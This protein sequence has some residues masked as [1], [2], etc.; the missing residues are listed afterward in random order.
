[1]VFIL[2][3]FILVQFVGLRRMQFHPAPSRRFQLGAE[4]A[5][6]IEHR[7]SARA[8]AAPMPREPPVTRAVL[9]ES[10]LVIGFLHRLNFD[11]AWICPRMWYRNRN[12]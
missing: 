4:A 3:E 5:V 12:Y 7:A 8:L 10:F 2:V 11:G 1:M 9:P 6:D